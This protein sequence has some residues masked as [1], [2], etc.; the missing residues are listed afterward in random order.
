MGSLIDMLNG[1]REK[2]ANSQDE[3]DKL[4]QLSVIK[5]DEIVNLDIEIQSLRDFLGN[6]KANQEEKIAM[7][8]AEISANSKVIR[9]QDKLIVDL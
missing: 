8:S 2:E 1:L 6:V 7:Y 5:D 9:R 3:I 4:N